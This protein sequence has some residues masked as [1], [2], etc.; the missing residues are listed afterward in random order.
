MTDPMADS[1]A[2]HTATLL[3]D[4]RV[5][6]AGGRLMFNTF[7]GRQTVALSSAELYDP[8]TGRFS[9]T[10]SMAEARSDATAVRLLDGRVL[11]VGGWSG[12][13]QVAAVLASAEIFDP[14]TGAFFPTG[15]M[16]HAS[17]RRSAALLQDGE[18]LLVGGSSSPSGGWGPEPELFDPGTGTFKTPMLPDAGFVFSFATTML[19][20]RVLITGHQVDAS[21][22][23]TA[24]TWL[25]DSALGSYSPIDTP[26]KAKLLVETPATLLLDG[27]V[28]M[29]AVPFPP[30]RTKPVTATALVY[31]P[32]SGVVGSTGPVVEARDQAAAIPLRN[33]QVLVVGGSSDCC[34]VDTLKSAE[35]FDP[36]T[37]TFTLT[38]SMT[39]SR[40]RSFE[41]TATPLLD[42]RVL[43]AGGIWPAMN[44]STLT[45][46][47]IYQP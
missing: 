23:L 3:S 41:F 17:Y 42:G 2:S 14:S 18:V 38:A 25:Y 21:G 15:P 5:L 39:K 30:D 31:D 11:I 45:L 12:D 27:R 35:L 26:A 47:E 13:S 33:G 29:L 28:L 9:A 36:A 20:G 22:G 10:G 44:G 24:A 32:A 43:I 16:V 46:A 19:D 6:V 4:G 34:G 37:G 1:R 40:G 8:A 7:A